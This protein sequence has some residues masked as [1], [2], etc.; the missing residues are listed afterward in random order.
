MPST[1]SKGTIVSLMYDRNYGFLT[2]VGRDGEEIFFH[3][4]AATDFTSL[5]PGDL[6]HYIE[7][8]T[9]KGLRAVGVHRLPPEE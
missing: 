5:L 1:P 2:P 3:A 6:V 9:K 7:V 4:T 8:N